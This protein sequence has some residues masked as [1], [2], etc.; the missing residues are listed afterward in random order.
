MRLEHL[1]RITMQY[2]GDSSWHAPYRRAD[3][4]SEQEFGYGTGDGT[5]TGDVVQGTLTWV[6]TPARR[7]RACR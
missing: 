6:N 3:G 4:T 1:C 2:A 7:E 5:V